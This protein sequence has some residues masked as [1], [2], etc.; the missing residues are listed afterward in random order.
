MTTG[1][2]IGG[3]GGGV[4]PKGN[5]INGQKVSNVI[6]QQLGTEKKSMLND[7]CSNADSLIKKKSYGKDFFENN[8][9]SCVTEIYFL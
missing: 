7:Q 1:D 2:R 3:R 6:W 8:K 4:Y 9:K 5:I